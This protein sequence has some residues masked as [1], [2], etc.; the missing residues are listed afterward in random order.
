MK[1]MVFLSHAKE[2]A[3]TANAI[4][5]GLEAKGIGCWIAPRDVTPGTDWGEA[6]EGALRE[7]KV[8][9]VVF[10]PLSN[11]SD[12]VYREIAG[13]ADGNMKIIL[14]QIE[15]T[16]LAPRLKYFLRTS[17]WLDG[18]PKPSGMEIDYLADTIRGLISGSG[19]LEDSRHR[20]L[21]ARRRKQRRKALL[22]TLPVAAA[23][24]ALVF[25]WIQYREGQAADGRSGGATQR[26]GVF[27]LHSIPSGA[28]VFLNG[29]SAGVTP[30][31]S[32]KSSSVMRF[33][34]RNRYNTQRSRSWK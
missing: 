14:F 25:L 20:L 32:N 22:F 23:L 18:D 3:A 26:T 34:P 29:D 24:V 15:K 28:A 7:C 10:S 2:D 13:A 33:F 5:R 11:A 9:V 17:Q 6:I 19:V 31:C 12:D 8:M 4:C 27:S 21:S 1:H 16:T 30:R